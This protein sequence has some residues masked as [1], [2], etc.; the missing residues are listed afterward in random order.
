MY[1]KKYSK[2]GKVVIGTLAAAGI[3]MIPTAPYWVKQAGYVVYPPE[4]D[5]PTVR[6][7]DPD[8]LVIPRLGIDAP[9][10]YAAEE[11]EQAFQGALKSGAVHYPGTSGIGEPGNAYIFGHSSDYIWSRGRYKTVFAL[12][13]KIQI[14]ELV[15]V[16]DREGYLYNYKVIETKVVSP[17]DV[18]VLGD[19][20]GARKLLTLQ[21]SYPIG[22]AWRRFVAVAELVEE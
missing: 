22:T 3:F 17:S 4:A 2:F 12:L 16:T 15:T 21:T 11:N 20:G 8:R 1:Q 5:A 14:G 13:P 10:I 7:S 9:V 6:L 18:S 19:Y